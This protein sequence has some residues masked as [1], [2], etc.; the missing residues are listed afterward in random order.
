METWF[1]VLAWFL[2]FL[3]MVENA[4]VI[5][6]VC[7]KR[8]LRT[9]TNA[10]IVSLAVADFCVGMIAIPSHFLC[11]MANECTSSETTNLLLIYVRVFIVYASGSNMFSL[12]LERYVAMVKPLKYLT[13]MT[14]R[15]VI[16]MVFFS[17]GIPF[18]FIMVISAI[19]FNLIYRI[20]GY[21]YLLFEVM[22]CALLIFCLAS[23]F[24]LVYKQNSRERV[25]VKQLQY[26][27]RVARV[28]SEN[29][30]AVKWVAL[31]TCVFLLCHGL[32]IRCSALVL[33]GHLCNDFRY[34][35]PLQVINSGINPIAYAFF[36]R[37]IKRECKRLLFKGRLWFNTQPLL[38]LKQEQFQL[39]HRP[40][41]TILL[42]ESYHFRL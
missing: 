25:L 1:W 17:W 6:L 39:M 8:Q 14:S 11:T 4:F 28:K 26:N 10:F 24:F 40:F 16:Q 41:L 31:V 27:Q 34:K 38:V 32:L 21:V 22:L 29:K 19:R 18:L 5:F 30:S 15:R 3:T 42:V 12:V 35:V 9:K 2:S 13:L 36:K 20:S 37:D 23:I 33:T 7:G